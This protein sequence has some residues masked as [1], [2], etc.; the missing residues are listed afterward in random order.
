MLNAGGIT[1]PSQKW[2]ITALLHV[3]GAL[4]VPLPKRDVVPDLIIIVVGS[5]VDMLTQVGVEVL[6]PPRRGSS[7]SANHATSFSQPETGHT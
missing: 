6:L 3:V 7:R 1:W 4:R 2:S 5:E